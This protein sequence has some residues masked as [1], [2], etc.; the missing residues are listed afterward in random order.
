M[1]DQPGD[2]LPHFW[3]RKDFCENVCSHEVAFACPKVYRLISAHFRDPVD[4]DAMCTVD[5]SEG[6]VLARRY[7]P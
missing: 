7:V 6:L 2:V 1:C 5:M 4:V 3:F